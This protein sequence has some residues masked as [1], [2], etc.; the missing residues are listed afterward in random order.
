MTPY[1]VSLT[2]TYFILTT[3]STIGFG[4]MHP[5]SDSERIVI[6]FSMLFGVAVFSYVMGNFIEILDKT[7]SLDNELEEGEALT[8]FFGLLKRFNKNQNID[9]NFKE[10][11]ERY[12]EHR[13]SENKNWLV[14][15]LEDQEIFQQLPFSCQINVYSKFLY[16]GFLEAFN[17]I[18]K[19]RNPY[20]TCFKNRYFDF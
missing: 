17:S 8:K 10:N 13:W 19:I 6:G 3:L 20:V 7:K 1:E 18:C 9:K 11:M 14:N 16:Y 15:S 12:F 2:L 4:D 5:R